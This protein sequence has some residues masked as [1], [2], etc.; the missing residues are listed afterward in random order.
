MHAV[1]LRPEHHGYRLSDA[2]GRAALGRIAEHAVPVVPTRWWAGRRQRHAWDRT[3]DPTL[4]ARLVAA[5]A[6][7]GRRFALNNWVGLDGHRRR[8]AGLKGRG[9]IDFARTQM[10]GRKEVSGLSEALGVEAVAFGLHAPF[11]QS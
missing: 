5:K 7:P 6:H 10:V 4:N 8:E 3:A 1:K 9:V 2:H 11:R